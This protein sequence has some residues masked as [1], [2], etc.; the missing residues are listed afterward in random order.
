MHELARGP[1]QGTKPF[2]V[3]RH[4]GGSGTLVVHI[5]DDNLEQ[6]T[7]HRPVARAG[8]AT[9]KVRRKPAVVALPNK[10]AP[11]PDTSRPTVDDPTPFAAYVQVGAFRNRS[12]AERAGASALRSLNGEPALGVRVEPFAKIFR[13]ELGPID[14]SAAKVFAR[15]CSRLAMN[16]G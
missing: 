13:A 15:A 2:V 12:R 3:C 7:G 6:E 11:S 16:A 8:V 10:R 14:P 4:I 5:E 1:A 9:V